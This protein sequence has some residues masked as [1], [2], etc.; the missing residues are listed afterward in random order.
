[1]ADS[2]VDELPEGFRLTTPTEEGGR[3]DLAQLE[4]KYGLPPR[5]LSS[6]SKVESNDNPMAVGPTTRSGERAQGRF[7]FMP[8]TARSYNIDPFDEAQA[9]DA[10]GQMYQ[11][12]LKKYNGDVDKALAAY[13]WGEGNV[14]RQG[15]DKMPKETRDYIAKVK[16]GMGEQETAGDELPSGFKVNETTPQKRGMLDVLAGPKIVPRPSTERDE[17][18]QTSN[19]L[20]NKAKV[21]AMALPGMLGNL[22]ALRDAGMAGIEPEQVALAKEYSALLNPT[23]ILEKGIVAARKL[24]GQDAKTALPTSEELAEKLLGYKPGMKPKDTTD[25]LLG[26]ATEFLAS[27][28]AGPG[29]PI[30]AAIK[31]GAGAAA[32]SVAKLAGLS[33]AVAG[34]GELAEQTFGEGEGTK[35]LGQ[36]ASIVPYSWTTARVGAI[37]KLMSKEGRAELQGAVTGGAAPVT[38]DMQELF[39][40]QAEEQLRSGIKEYPQA[41]AN[42][43]EA[44]GLQTR[45]NEALKNTDESLSLSAGRA[46]GSPRVVADELTARRS[47][48]ANVAAALSDEQ[49]NM[50]ALLT[51][52]TEAPA[53]PTSRKAALDATIKEFNSKRDALVAEERAIQQRANRLAGETV[54]TTAAAERGAKLVELR[55]GEQAKENVV[56][57]MMYGAAKA[58]ADAQGFVADRTA[59]DA[60]AARIAANPILQYDATNMPSVIRNIRGGV[61]QAADTAVVVPGNRAEQLRQRLSAGGKAKTAEELAAQPLKFD[62]ISAMKKAVNQDI[63]IELRSTN[64]NKRQRLRALTEM[65]HT[66]DGAIAES[67]YPEVAQLFGAANDYYRTT[68]SRMFNKGINAKLAMTDSF[69]Q[70]RVIDEKVLDQYVATSNGAKQFVDLF[71]KNVEAKAV[72]EDHILDRMGRA[73]VKGG[74][75]DPVAY[76]RWLTK[77]TDMLRVLEGGGVQS[78]ERLRNIR[79][80]METLAQ[81]RQYLAANEERLAKDELTKL[82]GT[83][84]HGIIVEKALTTPSAMGRLTG[85]L[86]ERGSKALASSVLRDIQRKFT[87]TPDGG[88]IGIDADKFSK[89]LGKNEDSLKIMFKRAYGPEEG[90]VHLQRLRDANRMLAIQQRVPTI[91]SAE[92]KSAVG[93]DPLAQRLGFSFRTLFNMVRA[94]TGGRTST[95][96]AAVA[97]GGQAASFL[98][99]KTYNDMIAKVASSP[100]SSKF[101]LDLVKADAKKVLTKDDIKKQAKAIAGML[102]TIGHL[103]LGVA[104]YGPAAAR[105]APAVTTELAG[106]E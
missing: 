55:A 79:S 73:A 90:V 100:D 77:N 103:Y 1:M 16:A 37:G 29:G 106:V 12:L 74:E 27:M 94:V 41:I 34:G 21:G 60:V 11:R 2:E 14:D 28:V 5:L 17:G 30:G 76:N 71:G 95:P 75:L 104:H 83:T 72:M 9:S 20:L 18:T 31:G 64:P 6:V 47:S 52:M 35:A 42:I 68:Y 84:E 10:A 15:M 24:I 96:D 36:L 98:A 22:A 105:V 54:P 82:L 45:I 8:A 70:Q 89:W 23:Q 99:T 102:G 87:F 44:T 19:Y 59:I 33:T 39:Q 38:K 61:E 25:K 53:A 97:L 66:I 92:S 13:N 49:R 40:R 32:K 51:Y 46:S 81:R 85:A 93:K 50:S 67:K 80:T 57:D 58:K 43:K 91:G 4:D 7:Q 65:S 69:G 26:E 78:L 48:N 86:G 56:R 63:A 88:G 62:D 3:L 101:L